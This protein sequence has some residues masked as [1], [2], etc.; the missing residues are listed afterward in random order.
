MVFVTFFKPFFIA[1]PCLLLYSWKPKFTY[2]SP[3][4][5]TC[6][7]LCA[8]H[9]LVSF[10]YLLIVDSDEENAAAECHPLLPAA[11]RV[12]GQRTASHRRVREQWRCTWGPLSMADALDLR[13]ISCASSRCSIPPYLS[14]HLPGISLLRLLE[15][16]TKDSGKSSWSARCRL[17]RL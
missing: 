6:S 13:K 4:R 10:P 9:C 12:P 17:N 7:S 8:V 15:F 14:P 1:I 2:T 11:C 16:V 3:S 5:F